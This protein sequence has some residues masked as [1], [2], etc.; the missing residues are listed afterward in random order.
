[1]TDVDDLQAQV[2]ALKR[3]NANLSRALGEL[4]INPTATWTPEE[5]GYG[6]IGLGS[7]REANPTAA[8]YGDAVH[9]TRVL[10][11]IHYNGDVDVLREATG[12]RG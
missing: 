7:G 3:S 1:M 11:A 6:T 4:V 10:G 9:N 12:R 8:Q 2:D 5:P